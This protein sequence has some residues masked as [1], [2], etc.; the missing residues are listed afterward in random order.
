MSTRSEAATQTSER[1]L[2]KA[3]KLFSQ[4]RRSRFDLDPII[5]R[6]PKTDGPRGSG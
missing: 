5:L 4:L 1:L 2:D 6:E 3:L